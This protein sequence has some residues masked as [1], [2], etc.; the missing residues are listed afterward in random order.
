MHYCLSFSSLPFHFAGKLMSTSIVNAIA[1]PDRY[2]T[3]ERESGARGSNRL[4][5]D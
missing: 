2:K 1:F 3:I 4:R 5:E